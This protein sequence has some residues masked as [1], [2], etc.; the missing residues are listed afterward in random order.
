MTREGTIQNMIGLPTHDLITIRDE[1]GEDHLVSRP[2]PT[3][4]LLRIGDRV[5]FP[6]D[7]LKPLQTIL[8]RRPI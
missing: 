4:P 2:F 6:T 7:T 1:A 8:L 5:S 3:L